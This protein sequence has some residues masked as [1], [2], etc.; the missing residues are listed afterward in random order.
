MSL[1]GIMRPH[2]RTVFVDAACCYR[3]SSICQSV[4]VMSL[5]KMAELIEMPFG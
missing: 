2:Y 5:A 4:T 1:D 3:P